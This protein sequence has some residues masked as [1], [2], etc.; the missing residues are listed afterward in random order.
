[1][2]KLERENLFRCTGNDEQLY[3]IRR[4]V[5]DEGTAKGCTVYQ[6]TT[7]GGLDFDILPD[8][9]LDMGRLRFKG[10]NI[11]Y[12]TKNGYDNPNR[13]LPIKDNFDHTFP[14]GM[15]YTCGLLSVGPECFDNEGDKEFHPLHGRYHGQSAKNLFAYVEGDNIFAGGEVRESEQWK[16]CL[17]LKRRYKIPAWESEILIEDEITNLTP[18]PVEYEMLYHV[19]FGWPFLSEKTTLEL[20]EKIKTTPRTAYAAE[21]LDKQCKF[22]GPIDGEEER[23]YFNEVFSDPVARVKNPELGI[24]AEL[25]WSLD[26]LPRLSQWNSMRSGEYVLG[27]E[28]STCYTMGRAEERIKGELRTLKPFGSIKNFVKLKFF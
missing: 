2:K 11:N 21:N 4:V 12:L 26:T 10:V 6:V 16:H 18:A 20:P 17:S 8:S 14:G 5:I 3:G 19:N 27:L 23:V 7:A 1:M 13:F 24:T 9:G 25:S 15:L 22:S 28:P